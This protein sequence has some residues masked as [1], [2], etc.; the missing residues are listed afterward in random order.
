[1]DRDQ[2]ILTKVMEYRWPR[3][4][5]PAARQATACSETVGGFCK[6]PTHEYHLYGRPK[7]LG[8]R[9]HSLSR[10]F[11]FRGRDLLID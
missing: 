10:R 7:H 5:D 11:T 9:S 4:L 2:T 6:R 3:I 1:M 8:M